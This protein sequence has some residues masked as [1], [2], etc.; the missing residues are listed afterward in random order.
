[1]VNRLLSKMFVFLIIDFNILSHVKK[2]FFQENTIF[3]GIIFFENLTCYNSSLVLSRVGPALVKAAYNIACPQLNGNTLISLYAVLL[4]LERVWTLLPRFPAD[5]KATHAQDTPS[6]IA[7]NKLK[8]KVLKN[9]T[10]NGKN[11]RII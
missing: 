11:L 1:M 3:K 9:N 2:K 8:S 4:R 7:T 5:A 10:M 6:V